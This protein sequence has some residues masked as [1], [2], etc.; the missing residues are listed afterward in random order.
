MYAE[1]TDDS[2]YKTTIYIRY[3]ESYID[4]IVTTKSGNKRYVAYTNNDG[5]IKL[6]KI[7]I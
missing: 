1:N 4:A 6:K 2:F 3:Q 7:V 5:I